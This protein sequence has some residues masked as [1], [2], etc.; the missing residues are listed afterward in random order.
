MLFVQA[1]KPSAARPNNSSVIVEGSGALKVK[2][3][4]SM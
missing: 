3:A 2:L 4:L 1:G